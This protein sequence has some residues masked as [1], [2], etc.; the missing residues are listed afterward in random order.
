M[1][2]LKSRRAAETGN[3]CGGQPGA[4]SSEPA[5]IQVRVG[6]NGEIFIESNDT[7]ALDMLEEM[8][9]EYSPPRRDWKV[10]ELKY[11]NTWAYGIEV[12]LKDI[13][14]EEMEEDDGRGGSS[15]RYDP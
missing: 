4:S 12:I 14:K 2:E 9:E 11:P 6:P 10:F 15:Y 13:F 7:Y 3:A 8:M 1:E 5:P